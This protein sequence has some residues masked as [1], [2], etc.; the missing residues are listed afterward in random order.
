MHA[1]AAETLGILKLVRK[2]IKNTI[3]P[4]YCF[5]VI[6]VKWNNWF[7]LIMNILMPQLTVYL[8][9]TILCSG[10]GRP[11]ISIP[12][13]GNNQHHNKKYKCYK[14]VQLL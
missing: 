10:E 5:Y 4:F 2:S 6:N 13:V 7:K 14:F 9:F 8:Y 3:M 1:N 12:V 11:K